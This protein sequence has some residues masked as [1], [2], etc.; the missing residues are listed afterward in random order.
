MAAINRVEIKKNTFHSNKN[1]SES[2]SNKLA[3]V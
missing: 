2:Q 1:D 3:T